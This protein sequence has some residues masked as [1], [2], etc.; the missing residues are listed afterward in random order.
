MIGRYPKI[1]A[2]KDIVVIFSIL[3]IYVTNAKYNRQWPSMSSQT[4]WE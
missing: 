1:V 3:I 4:N 2:I